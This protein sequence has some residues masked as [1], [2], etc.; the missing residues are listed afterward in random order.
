MEIE[1]FA[2]LPHALGGLGVGILNTA[3][4]LAGGGAA[5]GRAASFASLDEALRITTR[6][7]LESL[8][9][10]L[11]VYV[12]GDIA[13]KI[14]GSGMIGRSADSIVYLTTKRNYTPLQARLELALPLTNTAEVVIPVPKR[15]LDPNRVILIRRVTGNLYNAPGGGVEV[16][17][18]GTIQWAP[19]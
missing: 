16:L 14:L 3:D 18:R 2:S 9:D 7:R 4:D 17:Y 11:Y 15:L 19:W 12:R 1:G 6:Q 8:P 5:V 10:E 13:Q